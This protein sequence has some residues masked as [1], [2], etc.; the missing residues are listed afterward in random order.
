MP[1]PGWR[2]EV[3]DDLKSLSVMFATLKCINMLNAEYRFEVV[4]TDKALRW[5]RPGI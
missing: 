1:A 5:P 3:V 4:L 2:V